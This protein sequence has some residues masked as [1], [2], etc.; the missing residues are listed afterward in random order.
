[1]M[2]VGAA[3]FG[4]GGRTEVWPSMMRIPVPVGG[5]LYVVG[6]AVPDPGTT[7]VPPGV[8]VEEPIVIGVGAAGGGD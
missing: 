7:R 1:M 3:V 5:R 2:G 8:R 4:D 6:C